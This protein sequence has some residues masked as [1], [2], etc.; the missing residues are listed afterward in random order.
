M[1]TRSKMRIS[2]FF[3]LLA[4]IVSTNA[5][6]VSGETL[7]GEFD[8]AQ[9]DA[10]SGNQVTDSGGPAKRTALLVGIG[11]YEGTRFDLS[12]AQNDLCIMRHVLMEKFGFSDSEIKI[13]YDAEATR[14][15]I[16]SSIRSDLIEAGGE[17]TVALFYYSGHG[18]R[19]PD[20]QNGDEWNYDRL[21]ET[22]VPVD[23][24]LQTGNRDIRDDEFEKLFHELGTAKSE[25]LII[26]DSCHS[27]DATRDFTQ[28]KRIDRGLM[29]FS[30]QSAEEVI[31]PYTYLAAARSDQLAR[32]G[33]FD[34]G[35]SISL[36]TY[37]LSKTLLNLKAPASYR[38]I[39]KIVRDDVLNDF[40]YGQLGN[41]QEPQL[42]GGGFQKAFLGT[43]ELTGEDYIL[44]NPLQNSPNRIRLSTGLLEGATVGSIYD[45]F[46]PVGDNEGDQNLSPDE[47]LILGQAKIVQIKEFAALAELSKDAA[48]PENSRAILRKRAFNDVTLPVAFAGGGEVVETAKAI[49]NEAGVVQVTTDISKAWIIVRSHGDFLSAQ[50]PN[51]GE[52]CTKSPSGIVV[53]CIIRWAQYQ[54]IRT[55]N[56]KSGGVSFEVAVEIFDYPDDLL[57]KD[58]AP[59]GDG[60]AFLS[61]CRNAELPENIL[62][63]S[64]P[65]ALESNSL[66]RIV[67]QNTTRAGSIINPDVINPTTN[68]QMTGDVHF[69]LVQLKPTNGSVCPIYPL[70]HVWDGNCRRLGERDLK[71][72][73]LKIRPGGI[74]ALPD[75]STVKNPGE[76]PKPLCFVATPDDSESILKIFA[77]L[78][79]IDIELLGQEGVTT[80]SLT[81]D[82]LERALNAAMVGTRGSTDSQ[83]PLDLNQWATGEI[84]F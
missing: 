57:P 60:E 80:R 50:F 43:T 51:G 61:Q 44:A 28:T 6:A 46:K 19:L 35:K 22:I 11:D 32:I 17:D 29:A 73:D 26:F 62:T 56:S 31:A 15:K 64:T 72:P 54:N 66:L 59:G 67:I 77:T 63:P 82:P 33:T 21:D 13:L 40:R 2:S 24:N 12:A 75:Q 58:A 68:S 8:F 45:V 78:R 47:N 81:T 36:F 71:D 84:R 23:S 14:E 1:S 38:D 27:G 49:L 4:C 16:L 42:Q 30:G 52:A 25:T 9:S 41:G 69:Q 53:K 34:G 3:I 37:Y 20:Q 18:A 76:K 7:C 79:P 55:L 5:F 10:S 83:Q 70:A 74:A 65:V 48:I 39:M